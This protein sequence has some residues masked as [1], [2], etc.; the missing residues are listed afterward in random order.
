[1]CHPTSHRLRADIGFYANA[2]QR[3]FDG[4]LGIDL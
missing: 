3:G 2:R 1:M 4:A